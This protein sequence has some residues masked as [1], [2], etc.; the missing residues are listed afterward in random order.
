MTRPS[1]SLLLPL[2]SLFSTAYSHSTKTAITTSTT[3]AA[4]PSALPPWSFSTFDYGWDPINSTLTQ[5]GHITI[6]WENSQDAHYL[7]PVP[8]FTMEWWLAGRAPYR[9]PVPF[10]EHT[11]E[12]NWQVDL[13]VGGPYLVSMHDG[14]GATGGVSI[15]VL[16]SFSWLFF[17]FVSGFYA[18]SFLKRLDA[19]FV[20]GT[21][22]RCSGPE[23]PHH[24]SPLLSLFFQFNSN[25]FILS[26]YRDFDSPERS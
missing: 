16:N 5:C 1:L 15:K 14:N 20:Y 9:F 3:T 6:T 8:P 26:L 18:C 2:L 7:K 4:I 10:K 12:Y 19:N 11:H 21:F 23:A 13:P 22:C 24:T 17:S 25:L